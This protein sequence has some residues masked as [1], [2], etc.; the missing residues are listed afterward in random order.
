M[1]MLKIFS[2]FLI[3][4]AVS[5]ADSNF[6]AANADSGSLIVKYRDS[7]D[8]LDIDSIL[9]NSVLVNAYLNCLLNRGPC[10]KYGN[11]VKSE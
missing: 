8:R 5:N 3:F 6:V 10:T 1:N 2:I 7:C 4:V 9:K 11:M